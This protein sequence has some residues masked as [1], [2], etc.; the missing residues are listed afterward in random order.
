MEGAS[1]GF[2]DIKGMKL[3]LSFE[4]YVMPWKEN[5][6]LPTKDASMAISNLSRNIFQR[7]KTFPAGTQTI[8][9]DHSVNY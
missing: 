3:P 4:I 5:W 9:E 2:S 1:E 8:Q 7:Y 6:H